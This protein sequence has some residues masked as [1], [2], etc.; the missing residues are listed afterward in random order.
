MLFDLRRLQTFENLPLIGLLVF[1][2]DEAPE[3]IPE[4]DSA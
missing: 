4:D 2:G 3:E 1:V